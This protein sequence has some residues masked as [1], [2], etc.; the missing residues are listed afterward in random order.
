[1]LQFWGF[2][3]R[4]G[5]VWS[6]KSPFSE[7]EILF[8][9]PAALKGRRLLY[10]VDYANDEKMWEVG[11]GPISSLFNLENMLRDRQWLGYS[12]ELL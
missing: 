6:K 12:S 10:V 8:L 9:D 5:G 2:E 3:P 7:N 4:N 11:K 1:M